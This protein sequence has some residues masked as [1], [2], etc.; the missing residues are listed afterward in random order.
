MT[1]IDDTKPTD[2]ELRTK[3]RT[4]EEQIHTAEWKRMSQKAQSER[5][6]AKV[7]AAKNTA[8]NYIATGM[9]P[10]MAWPRAIR[11]EILERDS[12]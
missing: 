10:C 6:T 1:T 8:E 11:E 4:F 9:A 3:A 12:D 2:L 7:Q 5:L